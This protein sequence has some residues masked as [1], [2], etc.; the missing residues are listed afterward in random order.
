MSKNILLLSLIFC[1]QSALA[2]GFE[3]NLVITAIERTKHEVR[4][5]G[6]YIRI[7]YPNGDVPA[8]TGVCTD[9]IIRTYRAL[10]TDLQQLVHQD[11]VN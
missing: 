8:D 1:S 10:G 4:Y 7:A 11:M 9:V 5:D 3:N 6:S 2:E